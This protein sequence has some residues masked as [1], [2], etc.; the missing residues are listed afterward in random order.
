MKMKIEIGMDNAAFEDN[1]ESE[2]QAIFNK[3][4]LQA[5][6]G[7]SSGACVDSNGNKVGRWK[8][9]GDAE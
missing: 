4:A 1:T 9:E 3:I 8:I 7:I 6:L 2:L 5:G